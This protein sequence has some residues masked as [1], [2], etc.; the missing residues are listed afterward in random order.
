VSLTE[1][2]IEFAIA[3]PDGWRYVDLLAPDVAE[4]TGPELGA[5]LAA[6]R[7]GGAAARMLMFRSLVAYTPEGEPLTAG[8]T[9]A[10]ADGEPIASGPLEDP[11]VSSGTFDEPELSDAEVSAVTLPVGSGLRVT[12]LVDTPPLPVAGPIPMLSVQYVL[13]TAYGLLTIGFTTPHTS[14]PEAW[15][16][17]FD[18]MAAT[19]VLA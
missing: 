6:A 19:A 5:T 12:R 11:K 9:V 8:L 18:A 16:E 15:K 4:W 2:D 7:D 1:H 17:L 14:H 10:L 13:P 3:L